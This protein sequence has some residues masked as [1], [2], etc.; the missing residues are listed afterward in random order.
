MATKGFGIIG[1]LCL[2]VV[3]F[4]AVSAVQLAYF[5]PVPESW[6]LTIEGN[7]VV[8]ASPTNKKTQPLPKTTIR[9]NYSK[10]TA[11]KDALGIISEYV[12]Q[13]TCNEPKQLGRG[14]YTASCPNMGRD[15]VVIGE[16]NNMYSIEISGEYS[17]IAKNLINTYVNSIV[18]GKRI[19]EDREIGENIPQ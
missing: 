18:N 19:F 15:I 17:S 2:G 3:S 4:A 12:K 1:C 5:P 16:L 7:T 6:T 13:N 11:S 9:I 10:R 14:F 8:Y